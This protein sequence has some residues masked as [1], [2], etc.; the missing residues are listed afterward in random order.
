MIK[1]TSPDRQT[2]TVTIDKLIH[3]GSGLA[4]HE[5]KACFIDSVLPGEKVK[6]E[7]TDE[8][9]QFFTA[10]T[11]DILEPSPERI[12][13]PCPVA[14]LCGGCQ[15]QHIAYPRQLSCKTAIVGDC[16]KRIGKLHHPEPSPASASPL[17]TGYRRRASFK[18]SGGRKAKIGFYQHKTHSVVE[19]HDCLLLEPALQEAL[20]VCRRLL[21]K[22]AAY[23][24]HTDLELLAVDGSPLVIGSWQNR[25]QQRQ[26]ACA[27]NTATGK[28]EH[29][30]GPLQ[31]SLS[32]MTFL[33]AANN[34]YQVNRQQNQA[35][36]QKVVNLFAP[37]SQ[38]SIL[39]LFCG[40]GNFS[41]FLASQG[42]AVTGLDASEAAISEARQNAGLN[43]IDTTTFIAADIRRLDESLL[44]KN[45]DGVLLNPPRSGCAAPTLDLIAGRG[46]GIIV[47]VSCNPATLARDL[48]LLLDSGYGV[49][50]L[51][52]YDM[53]PQT[54]HIETVVRLRRQH[55]ELQ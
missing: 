25:K 55:Q 34:F 22:E 19:F 29:L 41:L 40:C 31:E 26:T 24:G 49:D 9:S 43:G 1:K 20:E 54:Y 14:G 32:G 42:A 2:I 53:F 13:P 52:P 10:R 21:L 3:G 48:R 36:I 45:Y 8:R 44:Q 35:L 15:W 39:D 4:R 18:I 47:Y 51:L 16:L 23:A 30:N 28:A 27:I 46:P 5:G 6:A 17:Q 33:R 38:G 11:I 7:I 12:E 50:E 37:A